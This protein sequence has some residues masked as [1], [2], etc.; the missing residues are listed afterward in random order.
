MSDKLK[1][2]AYHAR[3]RFALLDE[4]L[5][6]GRI[7]LQDHVML[8]SDCVEMIKTKLKKADEYVS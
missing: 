2:I 1:L 8:M 5:E 4:L 7:S 3:S 6:S